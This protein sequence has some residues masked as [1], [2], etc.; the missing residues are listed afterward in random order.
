MTLSQINPRQTI[1]ILTIH[2]PAACVE[3]CLRLVKLELIYVFVLT[4]K[5]SV[6]S[7]KASMFCVLAHHSPMTTL[8]TYLL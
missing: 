8:G 2:L 1:Q 5:I 3:F 4:G 7:L 6:L